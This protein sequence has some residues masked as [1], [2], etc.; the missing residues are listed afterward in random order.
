VVGEAGVLVDPKDEQA[1]RAAIVD[2]LEDP[3]RR[4][5]LGRQARERSRQF[6]WNQV[7]EQTLQVYRQVAA[8]A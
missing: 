2:L 4:A 7:A 1:I 5:A 8:S 6:S 3:A